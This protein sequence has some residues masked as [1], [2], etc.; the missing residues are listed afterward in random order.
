[1]KLLQDSISNT[2][3]NPTIRKLSAWA[4][5]LLV[6][7]PFEANS[8]EKD[9]RPLLDLKEKFEEACAGGGKIQINKIPAQIKS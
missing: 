4:L 8:A 5:I 7:H 3:Q 2:N 6:L 9:F 1:L